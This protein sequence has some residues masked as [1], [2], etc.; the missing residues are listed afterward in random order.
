MNAACPIHP[1]Q[2][3]E[4][5]VQSN[6][7]ITLV[8]LLSYLYSVL[9]LHT[10]LF[11]MGIVLFLLAEMGIRGFARNTKSPLTVLSLQVITVAGRSVNAG[12]KIFAAKIGFAF[13][14]AI[15]ILHGT[16]LNAVALA[17]AAIFAVCVFLEAF[18]KICVACLVYP[19]FLRL[20]SK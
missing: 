8:L 1:N 14:L 5:I 7:I 20:Y 11:T 3:K 9:F 4:N 17:T 18:F 12:P 13:S 15:L 6:A 2:V 10:P 16:G 19:Y